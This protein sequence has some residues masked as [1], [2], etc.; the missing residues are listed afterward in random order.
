MILIPCVCVCKW[1]RQVDSSSD[2]HEVSWRVTVLE[3][4]KI[5]IKISKEVRWKWRPEIYETIYRPFCIKLL[6]VFYFWLLSSNLTSVCYANVIYQCTKNRIISN[7][8]KVCIHWLNLIKLISLYFYVLWIW[9]WFSL[10]NSKFVCWSR[11]LIL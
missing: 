4:Y 11:H 8:I 6:Q 7:C 5:L 10:N 9:L 3:N 1:R 2:R